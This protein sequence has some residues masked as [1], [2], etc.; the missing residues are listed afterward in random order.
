MIIQ[1]HD[2]L[3]FKAPEKSLKRTAEKVKDIMENVMELEVPLRVHIEAG[4]NWLDMETV[5]V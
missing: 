3:V 5:E 2:E 4:D 1:V